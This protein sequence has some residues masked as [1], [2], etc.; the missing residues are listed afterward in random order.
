MVAEVLSWELNVELAAVAVAEAVAA[1]AAAG[2]GSRPPAKSFPNLS[3][4]KRKEK[5]VVQYNSILL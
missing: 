5:C 4:P 3:I 2:S 1:A